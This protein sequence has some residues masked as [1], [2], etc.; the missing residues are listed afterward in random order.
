MSYL[1]PLRLHFAGQFQASI[2]TVNNVSGN[3][4]PDHFKTPADKQARWTNES[5]FGGFSTYGDAAWRLI[6]CNITS[7]FMPGGLPSSDPILS[8]L[9]ADS[10]SKV[11][12]KLVDLDSE[13]QLVSEI[14]GL[15]VR[16]ADGNGN[17]LLRGDFEPAAFMDIW[18]RHIG[19]SSDASAG[20]Q[21]QS[22]LK[23]LEWADVSE[24][25]FLKS[26]RAEA[27]DGL[28]SIKFNVDA[29]NMDSTALGYL[30]GRITGTIGPASVDEPRQFVRGHQLA[31]VYIS[32]QTTPF[33]VPTNNLNWCVASVDE[34][35]GKVYLDLGNAI[36][37]IGAAND[38]ANVGDLTLQTAD[39]SLVLGTLP[40]S[41]Y[42]GSAWYGSTA[43]VVEF[44]AQGSLTADQ[45]QTLRT[46]PLCITGI[47]PQGNPTGVA[48][49][50]DG[51]FVRADRFVYRLNP[52]P[53]EPDNTVH[54]PIYATQF[55]A[56]LKGVPVSAYVY[57]DQLQPQ[58][59]LYYNEGSDINIGTPDSAI[60]FPTA[61]TNTDANGKTFLPIT[62]SDPGKPRDPIDGQVYGIALN[63]PGQAQ[64][65]ASLWHFISLLLWSQFT[66]DKPTTWWGS[67]QPIFQ[68]YANLYPVMSRFLDMGDYDQVSQP[69]PAHMLHLAF[70]LDV[71]N[72]NSMP[73]TRDLSW[74][75][76]QAILKW[77]KGPN[78][79]ATPPPP[80]L[81]GTKPA[82]ILAAAT[83]A[84]AA[85]AAE[86]APAGPPK[87]GKT[88][89][90]ARRLSVL[91]AQ[92]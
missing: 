20:A 1:N 26:L 80:P 48:E 65:P 49:A 36:P 70:G 88:L 59:S 87:G 83:P 44:P 39:G 92:Q 54:V 6:G 47:D 22:V 64:V 55:G 81:E 14:W 32:P 53:D 17:T 31:A 33:P 15:Q 91:R 46:S 13:Q 11:S 63:L 18:N 43:G 45:I 4:N 58:Q 7:A 28:L 42:A 16:I 89:A 67:I 51:L 57:N 25:P 60:T 38:L 50:S 23:N 27:A 77:L 35:A 61:T 74:A 82:A 69:H 37:T 90:M 73:V 85:A 12:A 78:P 79:S 10:D 9:I 40:A 41:T 66:P 62:G 76:R 72:P 21:W 3:F 84:S 52:L 24:Y 71:S 34:A 29:Y 8:L 19:K 68:Q 30:R 75:K 2:S 5:K 56:P 86:A